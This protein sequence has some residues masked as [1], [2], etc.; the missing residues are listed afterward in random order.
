MHVTLLEDVNSLGPKGAIVDVPEG[1]AL[2][3]LFPQHLA[4]KVAS[5]VETDKEEIKRLKTLK[6]EVMSPEQKMAGDVDGAEVVIQARL[7]DGKFI[8]PITATEVRAGLKELGYTVPK[9][10][11]KMEPITSVGNVDV[12][13]SFGKGFDASISVV[14][15]S[16][17]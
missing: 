9:S 15:E 16:G 6:P 12:P 13:I 1:Y 4:V 8:D 10:A 7:K 5:S 3:F 17:S 11:I 2:N 14:V